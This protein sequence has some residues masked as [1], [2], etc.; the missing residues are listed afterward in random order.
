MPNRLADAVPLSN[1]HSTSTCS[2]IVLGAFRNAKPCRS[3]HP[4]N[5]HSIHVAQDCGSG[6]R[7]MVAASHLQTLRGSVE[8]RSWC[9]VALPI[10]LV[11]AP[12]QKPPARCEPS[13]AD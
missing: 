13:S 4:A 7:R 5:Q 8:E 3:T 6:C 2:G 10:I 12:V 1:L 9:L 11:A